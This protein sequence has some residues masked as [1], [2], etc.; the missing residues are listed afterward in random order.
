MFWRFTLTTLKPVVVTVFLAALAN[1][2]QDTS[3]ESLLQIVGHNYS[4]VRHYHID[5]R[6]SEDLKSELSGSWSNSLQTAIVAPSGR[7]RFEARG[8]RYSW[9]QISNGT[10][11]WIYNAATAQYVRMHT[12]SSQLPSHFNNDSWSYEESQLLDAQGIPQH[13]ADQI[14]SVRDPVLVRSEKLSLDKGE[15]ECFVIR[16]QGKYKSGWSPDTTVEITFWV[17]KSSNHVR[18]I[19]QHWKG[20][21]FRGDPSDYT[22]TNVEVY[23]IVEF[24]NPAAPPDLFE[25]QP[26]STASLVSTFRQIHSSQRP[27]SQRPQQSHLV[28]TAAPEVD[29]RSK[30]G[31]DIRLSSMRGKPVLIEFWATWCGPCTAAFPKLE[32]LYPQAIGQGVVVLTVDEDDEPGKADAFLATHGKSS[33]PNYHDDGEINRSLPGDGLPEFVLIDANGKIVFARSGFDEH[34]LRSALSRFGPRH[35]SV[36]KKEN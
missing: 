33:W 9:L 18:K 14:G 2:Q 16:G 36:A 17:E 27:P 35:T 15:V 10:T 23:P 12:S 32:H 8:P 26:P 4:Q 21:L 31:R 29:F 5:V 13:V 22:R 3:P 6:L 1:A 34:E 7:Y 20:K 24:D 25:F 28:G 19:E 11:E 30:D